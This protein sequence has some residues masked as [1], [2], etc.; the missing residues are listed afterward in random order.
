MT[1]P[2]CVRQRLLGRS[3]V[4]DRQRARA[5]LG[6]CPQHDVLFAEFAQQM[7]MLQ[8][9]IDE[10]KF[11]STRCSDGELVNGKSRGG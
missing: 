3:V 8:F 10:G 6:V 9:W 2:M 4:T 1:K 11:V 7:H 5:S